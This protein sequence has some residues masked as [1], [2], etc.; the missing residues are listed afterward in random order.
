MMIQETMYLFNIL[1]ESYSSTLH[2]KS[3]CK[4]LVGDFLMEVNGRRELT[5]PK[6][7]ASFS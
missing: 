3:L 6:L 2:Y 5:V 1:R 4:T 7:I